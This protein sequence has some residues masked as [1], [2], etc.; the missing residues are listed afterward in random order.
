MDKINFVR[1]YLQKSIPLDVLYRD[2]ESNSSIGIAAAR[3]EDRLA[4]VFGETL[5][6]TE[7]QFLEENKI[8]KI[9]REL[10]TVKQKN[11]HIQ[12]DHKERLMKL[13]AEYAEKLRNEAQAYKAELEMKVS[14]FHF[15]KFTE[16]SLI[17]LQG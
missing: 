10:K 13:Q 6:H 9:E 3:K 8:K 5:R 17:W 1:L 16:H 12:F 15:S 11:Q 4:E 14:D 7:T 2:P